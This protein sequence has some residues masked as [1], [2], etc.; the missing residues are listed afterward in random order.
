MYRLNMNW[1]YNWPVVVPIVAPIVA[2]IQ[3]KYTHSSVSYQWTIYPNM[4]GIAM[5][6]LVDIKIRRPASALLDKLLC[7]P[8]PWG[9]A[10]ALY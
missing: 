3:I 7:P 2:P 6:R 8:G 5:H 10:A 4:I 9:P 1:C